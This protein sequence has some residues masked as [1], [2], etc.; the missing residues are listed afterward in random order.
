MTDRSATIGRW[1]DGVLR[2]RTSLIGY[3]AYTGPDEGMSFDSEWNDIVKV[4]AIGIAGSGQFYAPVTVPFP[5]LGYS[6][7][8]EVRRLDGNVVY[9]DYVSDTVYGIGASIASNGFVIST[10]DPITVLYAVYRIAVPAP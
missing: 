9:D 4:H 2:L 8:I 10:Y 5:D 7:F 6:P 1:L 3:D